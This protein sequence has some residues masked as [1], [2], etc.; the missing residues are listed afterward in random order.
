LYAKST[1]HGDRFN[2]AAAVIIHFAI[3][4]GGGA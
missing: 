1:R 3:F 2:A 4:N